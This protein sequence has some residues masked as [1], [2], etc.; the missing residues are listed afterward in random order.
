MVNEKTRFSTERLLPIYILI[1]LIFGLIGFR[2]F[3][4]QVVQAETY[5]KKS[6]TNRVK[7]VELT[8]LRGLM[9]DRNGELIVD[10]YPAYTL[11]A[12][13]YAID[14]NPHVR[15]SLLTLTGLSDDVFEE[16]LRK[17]PNNRY[18]PVRI[19]RDV[20]FQ[21]YVALEERKVHLPG[22]SFQ[23]EPKRAYHH[24]VASHA[25]GHIGELKEHEAA[26]FP[27]QDVG[28]IV[29]L[30]GLERTWNHVLRGKK[31]YNYLEVD[32]MGRVIG[33]IAGIEHKSPQPGQD[34]ILTID[35]FLQEYAEELLG[36]RAGSVVAIEPKTGEVLVIASKPDYPAETFANV[37]TREQ[38]RALQEDPQTPLLHR[39]IQGAYPPGSIHKM[40]VL[41]AGLG[42][43]VID[44]T[45]EATCRGGL[46]L[47]RWFGCWKKSGHGVVNHRAAIEQSCDVFFYTLGLKMGIDR[48]SEWVGKF[49]FG[50]KTGI[51]LEH[52]TSGLLPSRAFFNRKYGENRWTDGHLFNIAIGQGDMLVTPLQSA[53]YAASLANGGWWITPHLVKGLRNPDSTMVWVEGFERHEVGIDTSIINLARADMLQ[54]T[55]GARGTAHWLYDPRIEVAGKTGTSQNPHG[56]DHALFVAF[57]P[58]DDPQIALGVVVEHGEH[59]STAAAPI[60][61]KLIRAYLGL[62][63]EGWRKY[64]A[65]VLSAIAERRAQEEAERARTE[66]AG[67][68][69]EEAEE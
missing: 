39:A 10:N 33:P 28:D 54:V 37:L 41:S 11:Y 26:R 45:F 31:G 62:D 7:A 34:L 55:E 58:F 49:P 18:T 2:L 30:A 15:D 51:D 9:L 65:K 25:F 68:G 20:P 13:P 47:G 40:A 44:T 27:E 59:G 56:L 1:T 69:G 42:S 66:Q 6:E 63:E 4:L 24:R 64:R 57:A 46:Y 21:L 35:V 53:C 52:E 5:L 12:V 3:R 61:Y 19:M 48:Y 32:V 67:P 17:I 50:V 43:G 16:R 8:P 60:A 36:D 38:W 29:G 23:V 22:I 14:Q